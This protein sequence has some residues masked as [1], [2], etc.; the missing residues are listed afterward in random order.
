MKGLVEG[1][2]LYE[3]EE[4]KVSSKPRDPRPEKPVYGEAHDVPVLNI[5]PVYFEEPS[6]GGGKY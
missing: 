2:D 5:D 3:G 1:F 4:E 6:F